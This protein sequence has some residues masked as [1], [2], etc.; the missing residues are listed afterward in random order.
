[1][2]VVSS[3]RADLFTTCVCAT[4]ET[5]IIQDSFNWQMY[6]LKSKAERPH[7]CY[8]AQGAGQWQCLAKETLTI[9]YRICHNSQHNV[10]VHA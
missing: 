6:S 9:L 8:F 5:R 1:M 3:G 4:T 7:Q 2:C 10:Q